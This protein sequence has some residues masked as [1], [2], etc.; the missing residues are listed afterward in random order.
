M[1]MFIAAAATALF[2][3]PAFA[4]TV[5]SATVKAV[6]ENTHDCPD[7]PDRVIGSDDK[8]YACQAPTT[9]ANGTLIRRCIRSCEVA[10]PLSMAGAAPAAGAALL[11][12]LAAT[13]GSDSD[14]S[15]TTTT[16]TTTTTP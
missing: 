7:Y 1:K 16:T 12:G 14:G 5:Q 11:I 10:V 3:A 4:A 15:T 6:T 9:D 13:L 8:R 2:A